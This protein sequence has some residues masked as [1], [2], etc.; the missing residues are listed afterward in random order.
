[1]F[2]VLNQRLTFSPSTIFFIIFGLQKTDD[3]KIVN[4]LLKSNIFI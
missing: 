4:C 1:M 3:S 2:N